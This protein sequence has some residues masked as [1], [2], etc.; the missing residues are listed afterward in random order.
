MQRRHWRSTSMKYLEDRFVLTSIEG[1]HAKL[2]FLESKVAGELPNVFLNYVKGLKIANLQ[3]LLPS[4]TSA[5]PF[6]FQR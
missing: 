3:K 1:K 4:E 6:L 2:F 5:S